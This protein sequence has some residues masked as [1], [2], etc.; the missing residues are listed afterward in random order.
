[1]ERPQKL[2]PSEVHAQACEKMVEENTTFEK[3]AFDST[4]HAKKFSKPLLGGM[5]RVVSG[6]NLVGHEAFHGEASK[7]FPDVDFSLIQL[8][9]DPEE[10]KDEY[11]PISSKGLRWGVI[12]WRSFLG[13]SPRV[14]YLLDVGI[15]LMEKA[16][17]LVG[18]LESLYPL[19]VSI[20]EKEKM[21][22]LVGPLESLY[23]LEVSPWGVEK[24]RTLVGPLES[25]Y[26]LEVS[27]REKEKARTLVLESLYPLEVDPWEAEKVRTLVGLLESLCLQ[28]AEKTRTLSVSLNLSILLKIS[29]CK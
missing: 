5:D 1:M 10:N 21:R 15:R 29:S 25:F 20:Q 28:E 8:I 19:E 2:G 3:K 27:I 7:K 16:R 22:T 13:Q 17:T 14:S 26:P 12:S 18:L 4:A 11:F 9:P 24:A 6:Y 23:P